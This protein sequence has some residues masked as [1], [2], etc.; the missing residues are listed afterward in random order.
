MIFLESFFF[1]L[2]NHQQIQEQKML[3]GNSNH[4]SVLFQ[5]TAHPTSTSSIHNMLKPDVK[6]CMHCK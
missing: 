4:N 1:E 3:A 5:V 2:H 6:L